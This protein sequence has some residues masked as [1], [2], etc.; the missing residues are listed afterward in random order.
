MLLGRFTAYNKKKEENISK[1]DLNQ[2]IVESA[3]ALYQAATVVFQVSKTHYDEYWKLENSAPEYWN[4]LGK[5]VMWYHLQSQIISD[6]Q[7]KENFAI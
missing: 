7:K 2:F 5:V 6:N 3:K 1:Q 4:R